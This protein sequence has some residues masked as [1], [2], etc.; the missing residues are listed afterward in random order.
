MSLSAFDVHLPSNFQSYNKIICLIYK[1][2]FILN[3]MII[4]RQI[5]NGI[6]IWLDRNI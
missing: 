3:I 6:L 5:Q 2:S 1:S 4:L